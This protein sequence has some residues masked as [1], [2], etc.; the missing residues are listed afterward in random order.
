MTTLV[1]YERPAAATIVEDRRRPTTAARVLTRTVAAC[2]LAGLGAVASV[3][4]LTVAGRQTAFSDEG[5]YLF[6]GHRE[7]AHLFHGSR[8]L[9]SPGSYFSGAPWMYPPIAAVADHV[10]GLLA[11]RVLSLAFILLAGLCVYG[12]TKEL[13]GRTAGLLANA[14]FLLNGSV[15]YLSHLATFDAM[16][17]MLV[18]LA[19]WLT[20]RSAR[21]HLVVSVPIIASV[22]MLAFFTKYASVVFVPVIALVLAAQGGRRATFIGVRRGVYLILAF[23]LGTY[24]VIQIFSRDIV[25]GIRTTTL[26]RHPVHPETYGALAALVLLWI[27]PWLVAAALSF[28]G[29]PRNGWAMKAAL[30]VGSIAAPAAQIR[31]HEEV[32]LAKHVAFGMVFAAPLIGDL[33]RRMLK[34]TN[35]KAAPTVL[36]TLLIFGWCGVHY[37]GQF[38]T[39]WV[40]DKA[41][42][43]TLRTEMRAN[44]TKVILGEEGSAERY[45]LRSQLRLGQWAD[46]YAFTYAGLRG[47]PAYAKAIDQTHFGVIYLTLTTV[48]GKWMHEYLSSKATPY[49]LSAKVVRYF[50]GEAV[51]DWL[52]YTPR[53]SL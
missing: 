30:L 17:L 33:L 7:V 31:T 16:A 11:A 44:P 21:N 42:V 32:S 5:L 19:L 43:Q 4:S 28:V 9:E 3:I 38:L 2:W 15:L 26:S 25:A 8:V 36:A 47:Q 52:I 12:A 39:S 13:Y 23:L 24:F 51:G 29:S 53:V 10:G 27:G 6:M 46:T 40:P 48:N 20:V 34:A 45:G 37:S 49:I 1:T 14:V 22:L 18:A 41:L 35:H 50:R